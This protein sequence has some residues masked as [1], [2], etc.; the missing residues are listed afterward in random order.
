LP[1]WTFENDSGERSTA[2]RISSSPAITFSARGV[3]SVAKMR[4][5]TRNDGRP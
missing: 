3:Q 1:Q 4:S 5:A 2:A